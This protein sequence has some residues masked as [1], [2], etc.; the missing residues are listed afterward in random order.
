MHLYHT[1][2]CY[3][4]YVYV[5]QDGLREVIQL[6]RTALA[7]EQRQH[8][9]TQ[10]KHH[11]TQ[12]QHQR[13]QRK[14]EATAALVQGLHTEV[15]NACIDNMQGAVNDAVNTSVDDTDLLSTSDVIAARRVR[16]DSGSWDDPSDCFPAEV[17]AFLL[18]S[19][20]NFDGTRSFDGILNGSSRGGGEGSGQISEHSGAGGFGGSP[21]QRGNGSPESKPRRPHTGTVAA[22]RGA[23]ETPAG[24]AAA[25]H[26]YYHEEASEGRKM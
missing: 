20:F 17:E 14:H 1:R 5:Y 18:S 8:Q 16:G 11:A 4:H 13:T 10:R 25:G 26:Y 21:P 3:M 2:N 6:S 12:R 9:A 22:G 15:K 24:Q 23:V 19:S 7:A